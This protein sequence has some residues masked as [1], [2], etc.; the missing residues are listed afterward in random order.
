M[1]RIGR[2]I[3][4]TPS[5]EEIKKLPRA[6]TLSSVGDL[7]NKTS[8]IPLLGTVTSRNEATVRAESGGQLRVVYK[9]LGDYV[10]AGQ[11][12]AEFENSAERAAVT[13]AEG[14]YESA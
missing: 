7:S 4:H 5:D 8:L 12:I 9:H 11:I 2:A 13:T 14:G 10:V 6:V 1:V 3:F